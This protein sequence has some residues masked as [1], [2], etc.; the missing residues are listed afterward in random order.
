MKGTSD[1]VT[2]CGDLSVDYFNKY[3]ITAVDTSDFILTH[4]WKSQ[5]AE[6]SQSIFLRPVTDDEVLKHIS[7]SKK[8]KNP[9]GCIALRYQF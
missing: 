3:F 6:Q 8:Q 2:K 7:T 4:H 9:L 1:Q 5:Q